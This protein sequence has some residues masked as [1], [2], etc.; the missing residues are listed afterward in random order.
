MCLLSHRSPCERNYC[1]RVHRVF[2]TLRQGVRVELYPNLLCGK[3]AW[4]GSGD[5]F[6]HHWFPGRPLWFKKTHPGGN[7][8]LRSRT[9]PSQFYQVPHHVLLWISIACVWSYRVHGAGYHDV[10]DWFQK[11]SGKAF[12]VMSS[13]FGASGLIVPLIVWLI[14]AF[15]WR[16]ALIILGLGVWV[17]GIPLSFVVRKRPEECDA[18]GGERFQ[19]K[20]NVHSASEPERAGMTVRE[21]LRNRAFLQL[22]VVEGIRVMTV[23][24]VVTHALPRP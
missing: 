5:L 19:N 23:M 24:A 13:A 6:S 17:L 10:A 8:C 12:G 7:H 18:S 14:D 11:D 4:P 3:P 21:A 1:S 2:R 15:H 20:V 9:P 22:T 16:T